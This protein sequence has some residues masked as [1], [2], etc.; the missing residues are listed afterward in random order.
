VTI[1]FSRRTLLHGVS[2]KIVAVL[3]LVLCDIQ[4]L[5]IPIRTS[6]FRQNNGH[7]DVALKVVSFVSS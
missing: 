6:E 1:S 2:G 5:H 7:T 4:V 3:F